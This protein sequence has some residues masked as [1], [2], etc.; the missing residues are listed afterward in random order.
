MSWE[1]LRR[2]RELEAAGQDIVHME[3]GE[4]DFATA[5]PVVEGGRRALA[6]GRTGYLPAAGLP[7]LREAIAGHYAAEYGADVPPE[8]IFITPGASGALTL[9]MALTADPGREVLL[10]EPGYPC[11]RNFATVVNAVPRPGAGDR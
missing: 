7:A 5:E 3:I 4:P 10:P 2:A 11:N 6:E 9:A 1:L 8:R